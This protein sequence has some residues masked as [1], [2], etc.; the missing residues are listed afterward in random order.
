MMNFNMSKDEICRVAGWGK[1][2]AKNERFY[3][4]Y[5]EAN[6]KTGISM[7]EFEELYPIINPFS[8]SDSF[9]PND[10]LIDTINGAMNK[11]NRHD[12]QT[13]S[14]LFSYATRCSYYSC[15]YLPR[16]RFANFIRAYATANP[17]Q[18]EMLEVSTCGKVAIR[19]Y[20]LS[21]K[22]ITQ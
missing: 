6:S 13:P 17:D 4:C 15:G 10:R 19:A 7:G 1:Y 14:D 16:D 9:T 8:S 20:R 5:K 12:F 3:E 21:S 18:I 11:L 2:A 22:V